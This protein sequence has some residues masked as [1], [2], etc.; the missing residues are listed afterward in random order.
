MR[1]VDIGEAAW[2]DIDTIADLQH[3][4]RILIE[5]TEQAKTA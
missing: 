5:S 3:A 2:H 4:E 1:G